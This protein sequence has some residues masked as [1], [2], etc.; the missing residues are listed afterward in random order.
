M[1]EREIERN[2]AWIW[3]ESEGGPKAAAVVKAMREVQADRDRLARSK[4]KLARALA[5]LEAA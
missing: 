4:A 2:E 1:T 5:R 3:L